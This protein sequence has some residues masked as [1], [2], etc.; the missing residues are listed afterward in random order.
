MVS[1]IAMVVDEGGG[2]WK[3]GCAD[4]PLPPP[5]LSLSL[6]GLEGSGV[7]ERGEGGGGGMLGGEA[8]VRFL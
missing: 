1:L 8:S 7:A 2:L 3:P 4:C 5:A 6:C